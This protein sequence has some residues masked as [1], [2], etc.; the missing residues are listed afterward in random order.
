MIEIKLYKSR[1]QAMKLILL[2]L[3]FVLIALYFITHNDQDKVMSW[4]CL[5]FF[6]LGIPFGL[7]NLLDRR[8]PIIMNQ[9]GIYNRMGYKD[10][11]R[12]EWMKEVYLKDISTSRYGLSKQTFI[13]LAIYPKAEALLRKFVEEMGYPGVSISLGPLQ[14]IDAGKFVEFLKAMSVANATTKQNLLLTTQL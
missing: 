6:G 2:C 5:C 8:P 3:P 11:L 1:W 10:V 13:C 9:E 4:L 14:K 12:W 7:F